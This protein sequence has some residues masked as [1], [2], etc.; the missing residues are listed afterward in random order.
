MSARNIRATAHAPRSQRT[1]N[2]STTQMTDRFHV[3][4]RLATPLTVASGRR[5]GGS[6][7]LARIFFLRVSQI[8]KL[9]ITKIYTCRTLAN[10]EGIAK[11]RLT[12][13]RYFAHVLSALA[14]RNLRY[15]FNRSQPITLF[16]DRFPCFA[17]RAQDRAHHTAHNVSMESAMFND[18]PTAFLTNFTKTVKL[19]KTPIACHYWR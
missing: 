2:M 5:G 17:S 7:V 11:Y 12:R 16:C 13:Y 4:D 10:P 1:L 8:L 14:F 9:G 6:S 19:T 18:T 15:L 3:V